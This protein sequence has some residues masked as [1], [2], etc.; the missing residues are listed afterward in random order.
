MK[1][2]VFAGVYYSNVYIILMLSFILQK[3]ASAAPHAVIGEV[4]P[5]F[6]VLGH[7]HVERGLKSGWLKKLPDH[8][9]ISSHII[10]T[11]RSRQSRYTVYFFVLENDILAWHNEVQST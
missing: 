11:V 1:A 7:A 5:P 3:L 9:T 4:P 2:D 8:R 10:S 6:Q